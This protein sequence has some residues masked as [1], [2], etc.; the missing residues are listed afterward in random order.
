MV[1]LSVL[2]RAL[3]DFRKQLQRLLIIIPAIL[4]TA[5]DQPQVERVEL[6]AAESVSEFALTPSPDSEGAIWRIAGDGKGLAFGQEGAPPFLSITCQ[7]A[8]DTPPQLSIIRHAQSGLGAKALFA[9]LGNGIISRLK[10][11]AALADEGWRW[12]GHYPAD[13]P[14]WDVF[15]GP[16][17]IEATLPGAGTL[18]LAGSGLPREF[19][20][21][22]RRNGDPVPVSPPKPE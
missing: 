4:L 1:I 9:V 3:P 21:W 7:L 16:R 6:G 2:F 17:D 20:T 5:C 10:V 19:I 15:T 14:D 18:K 11:D 13:A 8:E 22:C 12:E